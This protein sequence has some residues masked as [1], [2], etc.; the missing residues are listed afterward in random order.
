MC[1]FVIEVG[2]EF[3]KEK[4][5]EYNHMSFGG[6]PVIV[7]TDEDANELLRNIQLE[8]AIGNDI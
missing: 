2:Y 5:L 7:E 8:S 3:N 4:L 1:L 6:P